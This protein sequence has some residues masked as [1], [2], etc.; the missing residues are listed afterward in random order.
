MRQYISLNIIK[1]QLNMNKPFQEIIDKSRYELM[2]AW[3]ADIIDIKKIIQDTHELYGD[4][5]SKK[6]FDAMIKKLT[7]GSHFNSILNTRADPQI[8]TSICSLYPQHITTKVIDNLVGYLKKE[9]YPQH[10][11]ESIKNTG[12][13]FTTEQLNIL[14]TAGYVILDILNA[15]VS[16]ADLLAMFNST[17]FLLTFR[18]NLDTDYSNNPAPIDAKIKSLK[19]LCDKYNIIIESDFITQILHKLSGYPIRF[20]EFAIKNMH[21]I[22]SALN[23]RFEK[24]QFDKIITNYC[25]GSVSSEIIKQIMDYYN[26]ETNLIDRTFILNNLNYQSFSKFLHPSL[27]DY[28]PLGDIFYILFKIPKNDIPKYIEHMLKHGYLVY[29]DFMIFLLYI[30]GEDVQSLSVSILNKYVVKNYDHMKGKDSTLLKNDH[31]CINQECID[32]IYTFGNAKSINYLTNNKIPITEEYLTLC[33]LHGTLKELHGESF[34]LNNETEQFIDKILQRDK[35]YYK[36]AHGEMND[37]DFVKIYNSLNK[38]DKQIAI[39][40]PK[41]D[42][43]DMSTII[44]Y[45]LTIT[46]TMVEYKLIRDEWR[47]IVSLLFLS[48][49]YDYLV[50]FLDVETIMI[51]PSYISRNWFMNNLINTNTKSFALPNKIFDLRPYVEC[52]VDNLLRSIS[53]IHVI[54]TMVESVLLKEEITAREIITNLIVNDNKLQIVVN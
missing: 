46:K 14:S 19:S 42:I 16:Y 3:G 6:D 15:N 48:K 20:N 2:R 41:N 50:D 12:Y 33:T 21:I 9:K 47:D 54:D 34:F 35:Y 40:I 18:T 8:I 25:L 30:R 4:G 52:D 36:T 31:L 51:A 22:A 43:L 37:I 32:F 45:N 13:Q 7:S 38:R 44:R 39:R 26:D 24:Q 29:D 17:D 53:P 23:M 1:Y 11:L 49:K 27:T 28:D 10:C 5:V